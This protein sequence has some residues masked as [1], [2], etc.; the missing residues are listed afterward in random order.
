MSAAQEGQAADTCPVTAADR[1]ASFSPY[2]PWLQA[3]PIPVWEEIRESAPIVR[4]EAHGGYWIL[5]RH[6]DV[7]WAARS[8]EY[9]SNLEPLIPYHSIFEKG[10]RQ[11]PLELDG[12]DHRAWRLTLAEAFNPGAIAAISDGIRAVAVEL[13]DRIAGGDRCEVIADLA[14][15]LPAEAF[16]LHFGIEREK[17][18]EF[19]AFKNWFV[20]DALP[21]AQTDAEVVAASNPVR[22]FFADIVEERRAAG[23][24][25]PPGVLAH[26]M[27]G[28]YRGRPLTLPEITNAAMVTMMASLDTTTSALGLS[29]AWLAEHPE[30]RGLITTKPEVVPRLAEELL[31]HEPVLTT[32]RLVVK[33][34]ERH[35]VTFRPGDKVML[36]WGMSGLDPRAHE[37]PDKLDLE[38]IRG[39]QLA[40]GV[41][42]HR[43]LGMHLARRVLA[44][45]LEEWHARIPDYR[46][47][48]AAPPKYRFSSVRGVDRLNLILA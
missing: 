20:R 32:A 47:D 29:W 5:T 12:D 7:A 18:S 28:T 17:L 33:E 36:A 44:I 6:E 16:L 35:G 3:D 22:Q 39:G 30:E 41:G 45:A 19:I 11:I 9:F 15:T 4:S 31:R 38:R 13:V 10:E 26:L 34:V 25:G 2:A 23:G 48:P 43:C 37:D 8:P 24:S 40:F 42:P 21:N 46:L 14:E 1:I 27:T